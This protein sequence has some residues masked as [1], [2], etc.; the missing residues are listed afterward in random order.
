MIGISHR[1]QSRERDRHSSRG[2][3][4]RG[5]QESYKSDYSDDGRRYSRGGGGGYSGPD[6]PDD[7]YVPSTYENA[8]DFTG[9]GVGVTQQAPIDYERTIVDP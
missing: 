6:S 2:H 8:S 3:S 5:S 4:S 9:G 7:E 1:T